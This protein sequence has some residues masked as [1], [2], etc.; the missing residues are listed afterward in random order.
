MPGLTESLA[1]LHKLHLELSA[2]NEELARGPRQIKARET[3]IAAVQQEAA[4]LKDAL[5]ATRAAA[6]RKS[7]DLKTREAKLA[8]L[9]AKLNA[10]TS[11]REYEVLSGQIA[12]DQVANSVAEDE[13]LELLEKVDRTQREI[14]DTENRVKQLQAE[15]AEFAGK[16]AAAAAGLQSQARDLS[17]KIRAAEP[18]LTGETLQ[19]Y[20]RLIDAHGAE[21]LA[22]VDAKGVCSQCFVTLTP[23]AQVSAKT[24]QPVFCSNCGRLLYAVG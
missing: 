15:C 6:D 8:D 22:G 14:V 2:V 7:L 12:A 16:V 18:S 20:R 13:I 1:A 9:R 19:R 17:E 11:N 21:A 24:G 4:A 5:K 10:C 3:K 23:Q